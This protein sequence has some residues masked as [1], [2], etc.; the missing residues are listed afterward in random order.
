M[1]FVPLLAALALAAPLAVAGDVEVREADAKLT[2]T[3]GT[4]FR[5]ARGGCGVR[6]GADFQRFSV[7]VEGVP[8][9]HSFRVWLG[10]GHETLHDVG[11]MTWTG[12]AYVLHRT[13]K[14]GGE[15]PFGV[16]SVRDLAERRVE[17]RAGADHVVLHGHVPV[18]HHEEPGDDDEPGHE[19][20]PEPKPEHHEPLV[21]R[22]AF[23]RTDHAPDGAK[24]VVAAIRRTDS[25]GLRVE[26][27]RLAPETGHLLY[28]GRGDDAS[29]LDD[30]RTNGDGFARFAW[31]TVHG[32]GADLPF[33]ADDLG[34]LAGLRL[35]VRDLDGRVL[36]YAE[37]PAVETKDDVEPVREKERHE[38]DATGT[39]VKI[40]VRIDPVKG[41]EDLHIVV[42]DLPKHDG[43][44]KAGKRRG[45]RFVVV[46]L[47]DED[48]NPVPVAAPRVR[49]GAARVRF[50]SRG[51]RE[52]PLGA[53]SL[54]D[55]AGR[56]W[57]VFL[58]STRVASGDLPQY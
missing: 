41:H 20:E 45:P 17:V 2:R 46:L 32:E 37:V 38:D 57:S 40:R 6:D 28:A 16:E 39:D 4:T 56:G 27:G 36:L 15:L 47:E 34:D 54:R 25:S 58:G 7:W 8:G 9:E 33:G 5:D 14:E 26:L 48:G 53:E 10:D 35:E 1:R 44:D 55:L 24:G 22:A 21:A 29:L 51:G 19:E 18:L 13:T 49:G 42:H 30:F 50:T 11:A 3:E 43:G 31:D 52:L 12:G 23:H